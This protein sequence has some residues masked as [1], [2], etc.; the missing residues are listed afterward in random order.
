[1]R[2]LVVAAAVA[3]FLALPAAANACGSSAKAQ[4]ISLDVSAAKKKPAK[5]AA[6]KTQKTKKPK[7]EYMRAAPM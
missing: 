4:A 6:K 3:A 1:M 5:I 7:V 2:F